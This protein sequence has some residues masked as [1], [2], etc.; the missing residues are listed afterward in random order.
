MVAL[1]SV[2]YTHLMA[3]LGLPIP[4]LIIV[5]PSACLLYTSRRNFFSFHYHS[6]SV[7]YFHTTFFLLQLYVLCT[8]LLYTSFPG[9]VFCNR[10]HRLP[11]KDHSKL[12]AGC[13]YKAVSYTHLDV[14]KRQIQW[15]FR[16]RYLCGSGRMSVGTGLWRAKHGNL[17]MKN[18]K[19]E[20]IEM[21]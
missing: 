1:W 11:Y 4:K 16:V 7:F 12:S 13:T 10:F 6:D 14:Y 19:M 17:L 5:M 8:C 2:S 9:R 3:A 18:F 20:T 15:T 21:L